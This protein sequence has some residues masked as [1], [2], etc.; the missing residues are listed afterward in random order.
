MAFVEDQVLQDYWM[1]REIAKRK[2]T[3]EKLQQRYEEQLKSMPAEEEVHARH[4]LV[5]DRG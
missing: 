3:P 4:I 5:V 2:V 1:Q